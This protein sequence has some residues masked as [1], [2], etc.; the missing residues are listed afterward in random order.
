MP[1]MQSTVEKRAE[2]GRA[3]CCRP[4]DKSRMKLIWAALS[5]EWLRNAQAGKKVA[6]QVWMIKRQQERKGREEWR[7]EEE[8]EQQ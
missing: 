2:G 1:I 6:S 7:R 5:F 8:E 3:I 4:I